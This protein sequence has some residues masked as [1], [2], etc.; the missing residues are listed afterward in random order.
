MT[1]HLILGYGKLKFEGQGF[2]LNLFKKT[3]KSQ[4]TCTFQIWI[5]K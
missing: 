3:A 5:Y 1:A 4:K 2:K